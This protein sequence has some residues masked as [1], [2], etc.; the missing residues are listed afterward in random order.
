MYRNRGLLSDDLDV[1]GGLD[2]LVALYNSL[3]FTDSLDFRKGDVLLV[4]LDTG[5]LKSFSNLCGSDGTIDLAGL[6][7]LDGDLYRCSCHLG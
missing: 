5:S 6:G 3:V 1:E 2:S 4:D 7:N